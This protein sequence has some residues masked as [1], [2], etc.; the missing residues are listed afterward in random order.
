MVLVTMKYFSNV[1]LE[2]DE[3]NENLWQVSIALLRALDLYLIC[4]TISIH[5]EDHGVEIIWFLFC[6]FAFFSSAS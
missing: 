3:Y 1:S 2:V 6:L 5:G 4:P